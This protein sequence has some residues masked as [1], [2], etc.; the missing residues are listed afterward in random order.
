MISRYHP[1][2]QKDVYGILDYYDA[3]S[4]ELGDAFYD[5]LMEAVTNASLFPIRF[6][7]VTNR[8][9]RCNL[10]RFPYHFLFEEYDWGIRIMVI[11]HN[12]RRP[13]YG[14]SRK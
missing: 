11:K 5:E 10:K 7:K 8:F 13:D 2:A 14:M 9:R 1:A 3:L 4:P 12:K 6:R